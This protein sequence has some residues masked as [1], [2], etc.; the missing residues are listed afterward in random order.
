MPWRHTGAMEAQ[1]HS[2]S[3]LAQD[4]DEGSA[5]CTGHRIPSPILT[6][7]DA[8]W[9]GYFDKEKNV[10]AKA[11]LLDTAQSSK[12]STNNDTQ[13][14]DN[15][16]LTDF[17]HMSY[18]LMYKQICYR[19]I[20]LVLWLKNIKPFQK[21]LFINVWCFVTEML[22]TEEWVLTAKWQFSFTNIN[23]FPTLE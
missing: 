7:W 11:Q 12:F 20:C 6:E 15:F 5:S 23:Q 19:K 3:T 14:T 2:F 10:Q 21:L 22:I 4:E 9:S 1:L 8:S 17:I 18:I 16:C 13:P